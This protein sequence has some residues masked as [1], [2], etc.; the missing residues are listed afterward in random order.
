MVDTLPGLVV[1]D[2][3]LEPY[4][5]QIRRRMGR[6]DDRLTVIK[7]SAGSLLKFASWHHEMGIHFDPLAKH[8]TIREWAPAAKSISLI[9]GFND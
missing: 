6:L 4:T 9:G 8:W 1:D 7:K 2:P 3:W 5:D